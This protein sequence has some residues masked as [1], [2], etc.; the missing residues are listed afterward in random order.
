MIT[1]YDAYIVVIE[2][3]KDE[4]EDDEYFR[5]QKRNGQNKTEENG[6][7]IQRNYC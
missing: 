4:F 1:G 2:G 7:Q 5:S 3:E 6:K